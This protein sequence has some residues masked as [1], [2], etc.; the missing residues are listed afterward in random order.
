MAMLPLKAG[1]LGGITDLGRATL[2]IWVC[3]N[4]G[5]PYCG[6]TKSIRTTLKPWLKP[7]FGGIYRGIIITGFA[8]WC[9]MDFAIIHSM[10]A[11]LL[12]VPLK[13]LQGTLNPTAT[14]LA[15]GSARAIL[16]ER[17]ALHFLGRL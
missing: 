15:E 2:E 4:T 12:G 17:P 8:R 16:G 6:W 3:I 5:E 9:E 14:S 11:F 13:H 7:L 10:M 1:G